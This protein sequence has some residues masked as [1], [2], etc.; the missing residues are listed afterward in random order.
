VLPKLSSQGFADAIRQTQIALQG[1]A[2]PKQLLQAA[3]I[4]NSCKYADLV[5]KSMYGARDRQDAG[6]MQFAH[7]TGITM[8]QQI[9]FHQDVQR[10]CQIFDAATLARHGEM[11][12]GA[13]DGGEKEAAVPYLLWLKAEGKQVA[14]P[15]LLER[16]QRDALALAESGDFMALMQF[17]GPSATNA[18]SMGINETQRQGFNEAARQ[19][20]VELMGAEIAKVVQA[21]S[22]ELEAK[23]R[24]LEATPPLTPEQRREAEALAARVVEAWRKRQ[25]KGG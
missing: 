16:V 22:A 14:N 10:F 15:A 25:G 2:S 11:L 18:R 23:Y 24:A 19:I 17:S 1:P 7:A 13:Y 3:H 5:V 12:K 9:E 21:T 4:L 8:E 6:S 20:R